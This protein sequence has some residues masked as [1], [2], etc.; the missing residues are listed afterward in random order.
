[1][2]RG[3]MDRTAVTALEDRLHTLCAD[4]ALPRSLRL[5]LGRCLRRRFAYSSVERVLAHVLQ[6]YGDERRFVDLLAHHGIWWEDLVATGV[7]PA[8][9]GGT[10]PA[11]GGGSQPVVAACS[12]AGGWGTID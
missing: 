9:G 2:Y 7:A 6:L 10:A 11:T 4:Q 8:A 1:M 5:A 3:P 12:R